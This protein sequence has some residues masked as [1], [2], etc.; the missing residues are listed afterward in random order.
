VTLLL[1]AGANVDGVGVHIPVGTEEALL[2]DGRWVET[3]RERANPL[4]VALSSAS[5]WSEDE[6][7][8]LVKL[9]IHRG[10]NV[11][12]IGTL[13]HNGFIFDGRPLHYSASQLNPPYS[14]RASG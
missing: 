7:E 3:Q 9:L 5:A 4:C 14:P 8:K 12:A 11:N 6:L 10:A 2:A 1:D 13:V